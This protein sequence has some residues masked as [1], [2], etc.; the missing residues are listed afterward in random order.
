MTGTDESITT[1]SIRF[2]RPIGSHVYNLND[3][4]VFHDRG[5]GYT[6]PITAFQRHDGHI[7]ATIA[8]PEG[9]GTQVDLR[10]VLFIDHPDAAAV[11]T[12]IRHLRNGTVVRVTMPRGKTWGGMTTGDL[13]VVLA[14]KGQLVNI[15][16]LGGD[17]SERESYARLTHDALTVMT[18]DPRTGTVSECD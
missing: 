2:P 10:K 14:D 12:P 3:E 1:A 9:Y 4:V 16:K 18:V 17:D 6:G 5:H 13:G 11:L 8:H 15:V 7:Y